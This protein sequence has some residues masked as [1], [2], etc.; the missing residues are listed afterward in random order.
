M[1]PNTLRIHVLV[2][3][4]G[5][6]HVELNTDYVLIYWLQD[7]NVHLPSECIGFGCAKLDSLTWSHNVAFT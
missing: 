1:R 4:Y 2:G 3:M 6:I 5:Y 7:N